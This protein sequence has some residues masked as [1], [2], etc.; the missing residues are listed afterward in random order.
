MLRVYAIYSCR[1]VESV[2][3]TL[4]VT[5]CCSAVGLQ[6]VE[7]KPGSDG[8]L[9]DGCDFFDSR[10][11][12]VTEARLNGEPSTAK[13]GLKKHCRAVLFAGRQR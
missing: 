9:Y 4:P 7:N 13:N 2:V 10:Q 6:R 12:A 3:V 11:T 8:R 5:G 1:P